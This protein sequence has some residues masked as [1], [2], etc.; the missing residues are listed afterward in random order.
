MTWLIRITLEAHNFLNSE[1]CYLHASII[2]N[3]KSLAKVIEII[4]VG[5]FSKKNIS[6]IWPM[7][8]FIQYPLSLYNAYEKINAPKKVSKDG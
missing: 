3:L 7:S 4:K 6:K 8:W 2:L 5:L 1:Q